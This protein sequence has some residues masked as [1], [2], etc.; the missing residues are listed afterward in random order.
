MT[1]RAASA[2]VPSPRAALPARVVVGT[3]SVGPEGDAADSGTGL[4]VLDLDAHATDGPAYARAGHEALVSPTWV[5][6]HP[7][8]PWL[9][10]VGESDP[11]EVVCSG[12]DEDGRLTVLGRRTTGGDGACHLAVDD[13]GRWVVVAHYGSGTVETFRL[14]EDG[15]LTGP[16]ARRALDGPTGPDEERQ[17]RSHAHQVVLDPRRLGE[18]LVCDLGT[19]RVHRLRLDDEGGLSE[20]AAPVVLPPGSGPRHLVVDGDLLVVACELACE[21]RVLR[22]TEDGW[23]PSAAAR[24][25]SSAAAAGGSGREGGAERGTAPSGPVLVSGL[26]VADDL[27]LVATRGADVVTAFR[28]D[29]DAGTLTRLAEV[30]TQGHHPR[31]LVLADGLVWVANQWSDEVVALGLDAV[32]EGREAPSAVRV[33]VPR[34]ARVLLLDGRSSQHGVAGRER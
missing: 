25:T 27:V 10:S 7:H 11:S 14:D 33:A 19:D 9:V 17:D 4:V 16:V 3:Y 20:A 21:L 34:P 6:P 28:L 29:R 1:D 15:G 32:L 13:G 2:S 30:S 24:T 8:R 23:A 12:L 31:D 26:Q 5:V 22:R 18:V